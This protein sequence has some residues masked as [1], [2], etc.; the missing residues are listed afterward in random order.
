MAEVLGL[1]DI[2]PEDLKHEKPGPDIVK[3]YRVLSIEKSQIDGYFILFRRYLQSPFLDFESYL[4]ILTG[5]NEDDIQ[6][7]LKQYNSKFES[8][9]NSPGVY[10]LKDLALSRGF[11]TGFEIVMQPDHK[12][13]KSDS[14]FINSD[15]VSLITKS[16]LRSD[17]NALRF[18]E[19][20]F[21]NTILGFS[22]HW[23][24]KNISSDDCEY[25]SEKNTDLSIIDKIHINCD[26]SD[27][28]VLNG[29]RQP[30]LYSF[31]LDRPPGYKVFC[32]PETID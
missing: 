5:L 25:Y 28:S 16:I 4:I 2:S 10:T 20:S 11:R 27:G 31:V 23:D 3:L 24:Y 8:Y 21:F 12:Y 14:I 29:V 17:N 7:I 18:D 26:C 32:Q 22:S 9:K 15:D 30:K 13:D 19:K 6:L 1:S